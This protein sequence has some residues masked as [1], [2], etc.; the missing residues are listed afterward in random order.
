MN[1]SL[2]NWLQKSV[3]KIFYPLQG[4]LKIR[5]NLERVKDAYIISVTLLYPG[6]SLK[7]KF[8]IFD[9]RPWAYTF[10]VYS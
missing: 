3:I 1:L 8:W 2:K 4:I 5:P 9:V 7:D 10:M 6:W